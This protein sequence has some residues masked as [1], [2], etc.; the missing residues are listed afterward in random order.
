MAPGSSVW[1]ATMKMTKAQH[2]E[3]HTP[4]DSKQAPQQKHEQKQ[5][6]KRI[7]INTY[8]DLLD[9]KQRTQQAKLADEAKRIHATKEENVEIM[10]H[11]TQDEVVRVRQ[12]KMLD[13]SNRIQ[14]AINVGMVL[15]W[16]EEEVLRTVKKAEAYAKAVADGGETRLTDKMM[17]V[18]AEEEVLGFGRALEEVRH[19]GSAGNGEDGFARLR[20]LRWAFSRK[21]VATVSG[22]DGQPELYAPLLLLKI[23]TALNIAF[24]STC[25]AISREKDAYMDHGFSRQT[26]DFVAFRQRATHLLRVPNKQSGQETLRLLQHSRLGRKRF[27]DIDRR[28][29]TIAALPGIERPLTSREKIKILDRVKTELRDG[30]ELIKVIIRV[31]ASNEGSQVGVDDCEPGPLGLSQRAMTELDDEGFLLL[32]YAYRSRTGKGMVVPDYVVDG[33]EEE[34]VESMDDGA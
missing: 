3:A 16:T 9:H 22:F 13:E 29:R 23:Q 27:G 18:A 12:D 14:A 4:S 31:L 2:G 25:D 8:E 33:E 26:L 7:A 32:N 5:K 28:G 11:W 15:R 6:S 10:L 24:Q 30:R 19:C 21:A 17:E 1:P 34:E 20:Y